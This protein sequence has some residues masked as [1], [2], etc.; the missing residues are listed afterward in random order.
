MSSLVQH[1]CSVH[2]AREASARCPS[3][4]QFF[5]RECVTEH[6]GRILCA[7]CLRKSATPATKPQRDLTRFLRP[8]PV[9]AG[10]ALAWLVFYAVG[11]ILLRTPSEW[12]EGKAAEAALIGLP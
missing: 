12:H 9:I 10:L 2:P 6:D 3:C 11:S 4:R 1:R 5:C 7:T 8:I